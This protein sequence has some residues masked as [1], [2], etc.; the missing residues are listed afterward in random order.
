[1]QQHLMQLFKNIGNQLEK[2]TISQ[3]WRNCNQ[4]FVDTLEKLKEICETLNLN[5]LNTLQNA[6]TVKLK[7]E[8]GFKIR[9]EMCLQILW[10]ILKYPKHIKYHQI[11]KQALYN[12]F[13]QKCHTLGADFEQVLTRMEKDLQYIGFKKGYD[14]NWYYQYDHTQ[15]LHLWNC[16]R[17]MIY[18]QPMYK[19]CVCYQME[20]GKIM[21]VYLIIN[22]EQ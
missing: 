19:E 12:Y 8:N 22:I 7:E 11:N 21:K 4:I 9:R 13:F 5:E 3:T 1:Q 16:Y 17:P 6:I 15:L 14:N 18:Q 2:T 20:N 10:N